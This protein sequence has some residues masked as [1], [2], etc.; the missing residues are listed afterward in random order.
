MYPR[1][2]LGLQLRMKRFLIVIVLCLGFLVACSQQKDVDADGSAVGIRKELK[3][4]PVTVVVTADR[5]EITVADR[6]VLGITVTAGEDY[7]VDLPLVSNKLDKFTVVDF[8]TDQAE[9][10]DDG[11]VQV[12]RS[13]ILE[14]FLAG[15]YSVPPLKVHFAKKGVAADRRSMVETEKFKILVTSLLPDDTENFKVHDIVN[16]IRLPHAVMFYLWWAVAI[17]LAV[18]FIVA[19][20]LIRIR[21]AVVAEQQAVIVPPYKIA[22]RALDDLAAEDLPGHGKIKMFYQRVSFILRL[23]IEDRFG[24]R[25]PEQ[26]TEEFLTSLGESSRLPTKYQSLLETF[27]KHCDLVKFAELHPD[28]EEISKTFDSCKAF[29]IGT[30]EEQEIGDQRSEVGGRK[31]EI[32]S[33]RSEVGFQMQEVD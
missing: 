15:S 19:V 26:T 22:L 24:A 25:A 10:L 28:E 13:Y 2:G 9:L 11:R 21:S 8:S 20:I 14:P 6:L 3:R 12:R 5:K 30:M 32:G 23:Y 4:G 29:V 16:P 18:V 27:L 7:N 1:W 31:S 17:L 33:Q